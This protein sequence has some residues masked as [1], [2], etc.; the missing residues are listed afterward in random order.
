MCSH[1]HRIYPRWSELLRAESTNG[2]WSISRRA[3]LANDLKGAAPAGKVHEGVDLAR[4]LAALIGEGLLGE[5]GGVVGVVLLEGEVDEQR[6]AYDCFVR[7][8]TPVAAIFAIVA[9]VAHDEV[10]PNRDDEFAV[11]DER[12]HSDPPAGIDLRVGALETGEVVAEIVGWS[13]AEDRVRLGERATVD[14]NLTRVK[15]EVVTW[16]AN[17]AF[18][19]MQ[20]GVDR[21]MEH[22]DVA[23]AYGSRG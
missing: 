4:V 15:A 13:G 20:A 9:I 5:G 10:I 2:L 8:E 22:D 21:V 7:D 12:A 17:D 16:K 1:P 3:A 19:Q 23:P 6:L 14:V 11:V 18:D